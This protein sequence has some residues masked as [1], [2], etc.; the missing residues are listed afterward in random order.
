M[1]D[2]IDIAEARR[3]RD[4]RLAQEAEQKA[5]EEEALKAAMAQL[6]RWADELRQEI[7]S[8]ESNEADE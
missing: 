4:A 5:A 7:A 8:E 6:T 3:V 1:G 2:V